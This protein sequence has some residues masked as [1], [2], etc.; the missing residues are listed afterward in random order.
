MM[1]ELRRADVDAASL[2]RIDVRTTSLRCH[3]LDY[4][5][6]YTPPHNFTWSN[7]KHK[8]SKIKI[9][10]QNTE[11][12]MCLPDWNGLLYSDLLHLT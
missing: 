1:S 2:R 12:L 10:H 7:L 4:Y 8:M 11:K 3:V 5:I 6:K 9:N